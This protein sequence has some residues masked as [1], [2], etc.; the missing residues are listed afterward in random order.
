MGLEKKTILKL[1]APYISVV[2]LDISSMAQKKGHVW[3][4]EVGQ[5]DNLSARVNHRRSTL[6]LNCLVKNANQKNNFTLPV[7]CCDWYPVEDWPLTLFWVSC[8]TIAMAWHQVT[9]LKSV[10][11]THETACFQS[12]EEKKVYWTVYF[13]SILCKCQIYVAQYKKQNRKGNRK[14]L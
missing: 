2:M 10:P 1:K 14:G 6:F 13:F 3:Q 4:M 5:E 8:Y 7:L 9:N 11:G 12:F